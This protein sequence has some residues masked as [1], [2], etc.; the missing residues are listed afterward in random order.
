MKYP[1]YLILQLNLQKDAAASFN[2]IEDSGVNA[3]LVNAVFDALLNTVS[4]VYGHI[5]VV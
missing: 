3:N 2:T 5:P 1:T 4:I